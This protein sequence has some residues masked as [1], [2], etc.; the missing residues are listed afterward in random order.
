MLQGEFVSEFILAIVAVVR[1]FFGSRSATRRAQIIR[2]TVTWLILLAVVV[3]DP[4]P[5]WHRPPGLFRVFS[6]SSE[7][8]NG[9]SWV[10]AASWS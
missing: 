3:C 10:S 4:E 2:P 7:Y 6:T 8:Y 1:V 9:W 5:R